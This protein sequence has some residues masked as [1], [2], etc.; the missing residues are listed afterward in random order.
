MAYSRPKRTMTPPNS[1]PAPVT[2]PSK[3]QRGSPG[4]PLDGSE[5]S[6][7]TLRRSSRIASLDS[8]PDAVTAVLDMT[9][10]VRPKPKKAQNQEEQVASRRPARLDSTTA[11]VQCSPFRSTTPRTPLSAKRMIPCHR[12]SMRPSERSSIW[13]RFWRTGWTQ[14]PGLVMGMYSCPTTFD[15]CLFPNMI[16]TVEA[17]TGIVW[18]NPSAS[19]SVE[20][21]YSRGLR[22]GTRTF[23]SNLFSLRASSARVSHTIAPSY[24][25]ILTSNRPTLAVLVSEY[26]S[27]NNTL[28]VARPAPVDSVKNA[29]FRGVMCSIRGRT[30]TCRCNTL[31]VRPAIDGKKTRQV[32]SWWRMIL[33]S[34]PSLNARRPKL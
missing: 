31:A 9:Q 21:W 6:P 17:S 15:P 11:F 29:V 14:N 5:R 1:T 8:M 7:L 3:R 2:H 25:I 34:C 22:A 28:T 16:A 18:P 20:V 10:P 19:A 32:T 33:T 12:S 13:V 24:G 30:I 23:P 26:G 4:L 27:A